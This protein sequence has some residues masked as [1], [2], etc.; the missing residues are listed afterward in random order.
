MVLTFF[1]NICVFKYCGFVDICYET[2]CILFKVV[3]SS[4]NFIE[5]EIR[6]NLKS[7]ALAMTDQSV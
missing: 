6:V 4:A 5:D 3:I 2:V 1:K 7:G